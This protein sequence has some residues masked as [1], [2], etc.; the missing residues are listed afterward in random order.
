ML[1]KRLFL[2]L[3]LI[4]VAT[5]CGG[6]GGGSNGG[7]TNQVC[8]ETSVY[9][10][11]SSVWGDP[12]GIA[13]VFAWYSGQCTQEV[14]CEDDLPETDT[15]AGVIREDFIQE[16]WVSTSTTEAEPNDSFDEA[17]PNIIAAKQGFL[18]TGNVGDPDDLA[19]YVVVAVQDNITLAAYLCSAVDKCTQPFYSGSDAHIEIYDENRVLLHATPPSPINGHVHN[20]QAVAGLK[21]YVAVVAEPNVP[22]YTYKLVITD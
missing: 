12:F 20:F 10:C 19:D 4:I 3:V 18:I 9:F 21:Y 8:R 2:P 13:L 6:G 1:C 14:G 15:E 7:G 17:F 22:E 5:S 16:E 11:P